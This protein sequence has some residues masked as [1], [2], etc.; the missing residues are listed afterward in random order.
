MAVPCVSHRFLRPWSM[1]P[2]INIKSMSPLLPSLRSPRVT[3]FNPFAPALGHPCWGEGGRTEGRKPGQVSVPSALSRRSVQPWA[4]LSVPKSFQRA[5]LG[6]DHSDTPVDP[7]GSTQSQS[8]GG[9]TAM[10]PCPWG[11]PCPPCLTPR[12][13]QPQAWLQSGMS[14]SPLACPQ[15]RWHWPCAPPPRLSPPD[16]ARASPSFPPVLGNSLTAHSWVLL[17]RPSCRKINPFLPPLQ[18]QDPP[19][20]TQ[21]RGPAAPP[22]RHMGTAR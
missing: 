22:A 4:L 20:V 10:L 2:S 8:C 12:G 6:T 13:A 16:G 1:Q 5:K 17:G 21:G 7:Q 11:D 15:T 9:V 3:P 18:A 19:T 14:P